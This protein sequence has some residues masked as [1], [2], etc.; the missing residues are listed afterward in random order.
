M[1]EMSDSIITVNSESDL[2][3]RTGIHL[4]ANMGS[5]AVARVESMLEE[6]LPIAFRIFASDWSYLLL[7]YAREAEC[8][9]LGIGFSGQMGAV[10]LPGRVARRRGEN[11][12]ERL[13]DF[14]FMY[15]VSLR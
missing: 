4:G 6:M 1:R 8:I 7:S 13:G 12:F 2:M 11:C 15:W 10:L 14:G 5:V 3:V 9:W